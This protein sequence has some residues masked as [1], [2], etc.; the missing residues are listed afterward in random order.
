M[1]RDPITADV[2]ARLIAG[3]FP[4]WADLPV[5]P[6]NLNGWDNTTFRVGSELPVRLPTADRYTAQIAKEHR[7]L[8]ILAPRLP[9]PIP[10]P[11]A[12]GR[13]SEEFPR[14]WSVYRWIAGEPASADQVADP[15]KFASSLAGFLAAL[16][17]RHSPPMTS[18][19]GG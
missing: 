12:L 17:S 1:D 9:L 15:A 19:P 5:V 13:P 10:V 2:A 3:Q 11:V 18:R 6:V 16:Q 14:P 7:W 8:P 4:Q